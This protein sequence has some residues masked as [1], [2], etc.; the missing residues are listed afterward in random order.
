MD[1][2][3]LHELTAAYALDALDADEAAAYERHL[4]DCESCR[5]ELAR[6]SPAATA[7][8]YAVPPRAPR[9]ELRARILEAAAAER[10]NV[11]PLRRRGSSFG[12]RAAVAVA[13]VA[14]CAAVGLGA[15]DVSLH[16]RLD[17]DEQAVQSVPLVGATGS[18]VVAPTGRAALVVASLPA[19]P[20]GKTYEAWVIRNGAAAPAG[21][22][23]GGARTTVVKLTEPVPSGS[24]VAVTIEPAA[25][26]AQPTTHPLIT[27]QTV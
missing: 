10:A 21:L 14:A 15:W 1:E 20:A 23:A 8:A 6:L 27:S 26:S 12:S 3:E 18:V 17:R 5:H 19:A 25:G 24:T 22:F 16:H 9:P 7:L 2:D 4:E 13:A 11:V